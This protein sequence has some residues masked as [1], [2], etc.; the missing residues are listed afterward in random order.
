MA[1]RLY[2]R[3]VALSHPGDPVALLATGRLEALSGTL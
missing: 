1:L 3:T 2:G